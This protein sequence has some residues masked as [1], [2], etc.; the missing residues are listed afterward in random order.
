M[1]FFHADVGDICFFSK[2]SV[3]PKYAL[4][5]V[6]LFSLKVYLYPMKKNN[7]ACKL[8]LFYREIEPKR[9]QKQEMGLQPDLEFLQNEIKKLNKKYNVDMFSAKLRAGKAFATKRK[10]R[11][12][13]KLLFKSKRLHKAIKTGR[14]DPRKLIRNAV[15]NMN[16]VNSQKY[17]VPPETVEKK[18]LE[19]EKCQEVYDFHRMVRVSRDAERYKRNDIRFDKKTRKKLLSPLTVGEKVLVLAERLRKK[20]APGNLYKSTTENISF[21]NREEIFIVR[22]V[23]SKEYSYNYWTSKTADD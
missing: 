20:D 23:L 17:D 11:E 19:D 13:K 14:L 16:N 5:C 9:D 21:F 15:Q 3:D 2:S 8:E 4:L 1:Q 6:D 12:F 10:I 7:L 22:K 18:S